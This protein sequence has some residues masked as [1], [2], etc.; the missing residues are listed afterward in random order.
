MQDR[1]IL[2]SML[3]ASA[4]ALAVT[5]I[6]VHRLSQVACEATSQVDELETRLSREE[7]DTS[8]RLTQ[9]DDS[10]HAVA[11]RLSHVETSH[12]R[13]E[14]D[15][16][17]TVARASARFEHDLETNVGCLR[18]KLDDTEKTLSLQG[19]RL[20]VLDV[21][22]E[23]ARDAL[24]R[25]LILPAVQIRCGGDIGAGVLVYSRPGANGAYETYLLTAHHVVSDMI[26]RVDSAELRDSVDVRIL[27][28]GSDKY[29]DYPARIVTYSEEHDL[30]L[31]RL[32]SDQPFEHIARLAGH[33]K[34]KDIRCFEPI[35]TVGCPLG[36]DPMPSRG[37]ITCRNKEVRGEL[38]WIVSAPTIFGNSGGG[39]FLEEGH[40]LVGICSMVCV[41]QNLIPVPVSH[42][43]VV[44]PGE[45]VLSWL[46]SQSYQFLYD[47]SV[48][49][50]ACDWTRA[51]MREVD[52]DLL[53]VTWDD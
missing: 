8:A 18:A 34:L 37:E 51:A 22:P 5:Q 36:H 44:V 35:Y 52:Q 33:E 28:P 48:S 3:V 40:E 13:F 14:H 4:G 16:N 38:L 32:D 45:T 27:D 10:T 50:A 23:V 25:D 12:A 6:Q 1:M 24:R 43:G 26:G 2:W 53:A 41:Y 11:D 42:M 20:A 30:A 31:L 19:A 29:R 49:R 7:R 46:D 21:S 39:V 47:D 9:V 17:V 15:T